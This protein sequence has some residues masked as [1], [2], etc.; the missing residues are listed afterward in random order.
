MPPFPHEYVGRAPAEEFCDLA[1]RGRRFALVATRA[2][3]QPAFGMYLRT[4]DGLLLGTG[5]LVLE[6]AGDQVTAMTRFEAETLAYFGL[7]PTWSG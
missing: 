7:P 4:P 6:L 2:N 1:I 5:L 3:G